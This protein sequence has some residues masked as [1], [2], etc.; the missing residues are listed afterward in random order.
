MPSSDFLFSS[1]L[2]WY[3]SWNRSS[4]DMLYF[5]A[6]SCKVVRSKNVLLLRLN[7]SHDSHRVQRDTDT[8]HAT[9]WLIHWP[10]SMARVASV[11][12]AAWSSRWLITQLTNGQH[13]CMLVFVPEDPAVQTISRDVSFVSSALTWCPISPSDLWRQV[14]GWVYWQTSVHY[15]C[16]PCVSPVTVY[17]TDGTLLILNIWS[18]LAI[19]VMSPPLPNTIILPINDKSVLCTLAV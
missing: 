19:T 11:S 10:A 14:F 18:L 7:P 15:H 3:T 16:R 8:Y 9:G 4:A 6:M 2:A 12:H 13:T 17:R 1:R 5:A